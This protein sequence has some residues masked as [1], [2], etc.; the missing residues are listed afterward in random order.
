MKLLEGLRMMVL[1]G[2]VS[3]S[4]GVPSGRKYWGWDVELV[5]VIWIWSGAGGA[6]LKSL[7][8]AAVDT[9]GR[10]QLDDDDDDD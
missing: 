1:Y 9:V 5:V 10:S 3:W 4:E 8:I 2:M 7:M 6:N